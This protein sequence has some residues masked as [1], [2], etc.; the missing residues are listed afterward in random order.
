MTV[1]IKYNEMVDMTYILVD[2][3]YIGFIN[4]ELKRSISKR[5]S[6]DNGTIWI[7]EE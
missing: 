2:G 3:H 7:M 5:Y 1:S 4:G 6:N